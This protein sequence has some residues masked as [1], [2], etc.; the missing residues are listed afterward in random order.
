[1]IATATNTVSATKTVGTNPIAIA[2]MNNG[3]SAYVANS[4]SSNMSVINTATNTVAATVTVGSTPNAVAITPDSSQAYVTNSGGSTVSVI[5]TTSN[6]VST[7]IS[8]GSAPD[9]V[10]ISQ[11]GTR[12][13]VANS[14][15]GT[16]SAINPLTNTV[17]TSVTVGSTPEALAVTPDATQAYVVNEGAGTLSVINTEINDSAF[18]YDGLGNRVRIVET[19][20]GAVTSTRQFVGGEIRDAS[21]TIVAQCFPGGENQSSTNYYYVFDHLSNVVGLVNSSGTLVTSVTYDDFG[22]A[23]VTFLSGSVMPNFLYAGLYNHGPSGLYLSATRAY[24]PN[25]GRWISRDPIKKRAERIF[26]ATS[27]I[28]QF[29]ELIPLV[30]RI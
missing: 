13:Y 3:A 29:P 27:R 23:T 2:I 24:N 8:V 6:T 12:V 22:R 4:G 20:S 17:A 1:M 25:L 19:A 26:T 5:S 11:D 18:S 7:S 21:S 30:W 10:A 15:S 28:T 16:V 9:A 14:T